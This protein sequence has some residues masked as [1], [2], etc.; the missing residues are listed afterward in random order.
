[1]DPFPVP[2]WPLVKVIHETA[3]EAAR[4]QL[5]ALAVMLTV[6]AP[7]TAAKEPAPGENV[8]VHAAVCVTDT[9]VL[10][11]IMLA[12]RDA[13]VVFAGAANV[14]VPSPLPAPVL[15]VSQL[16]LLEAVQLQVV[17][18]MRVPAP[19][20]AERVAEAGVTRKSQTAAACVT[21]TVWPAIV[22]VPVRDAAEVLRATANPA[23]PLP[24]PF[25]PKDTVSQ[26]GEL[27]TV[28]HAQLVGVPAMVT[29]PVPPVA[30]KDWLLGATE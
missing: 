2:V 30:G 4:S 27:L 5:A 6:P 8:K 16:A 7:P 13:P 28:V 18:T 26:G 29:K 19:P 24:V 21:V 12:V 3:L 1:M 17:S 9:V 22:N 14:T 15:T 11:T 20:A 10:P 25:C 23:D